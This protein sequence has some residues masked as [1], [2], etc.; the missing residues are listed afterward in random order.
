[1]KIH[2]KLIEIYFRIL[3][4]GNKVYPISGLFN[5]HLKDYIEKNSG[6]GPL[7]LWYKLVIIDNSDRLVY[8]YEHL[9]PEHAVKKEDFVSFPGIIEERIALFGGSRTMDD[10][11]EEIFVEELSKFVTG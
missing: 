6:E 10:I 7:S 8:L 9:K 11:L 5:D 3:H 1:M 4:K 2:S